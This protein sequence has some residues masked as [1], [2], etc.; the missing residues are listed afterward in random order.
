MADLAQPY[1]LPMGLTGIPA[2]GPVRSIA[3][4][5][6]PF[7][8]V[9]EMAQAGGINPL[10][11]RLKMTEHEPDWQAVLKVMKEK[12][13]FRTDLPRGEGMGIAMSPQTGSDG[14]FLMENLPESTYYLVA[15]RRGAA[16]T[17]GGVVG[18]APRHGA[19]GP[20]C[21]HAAR[22]R[23]RSGAWTGRTAH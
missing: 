11:W 18:R 7:Q 1:T 19:G 9:D 12:S 5:V 13:G 16:G 4:D 15:R 3:E 17:G 8:P 20:R 21:R 10:D 23:P 6:K 2:Q 22:A 14:S